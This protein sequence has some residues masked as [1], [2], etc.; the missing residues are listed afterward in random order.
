[1]VYAS[2]FPQRFL[3]LQAMFVLGFPSTTPSTAPVTSPSASSTTAGVTIPPWQNDEGA[4]TQY[5][6]T[7]QNDPQKPYTT[8]PSSN[9]TTTLS[10][11]SD[12][13]T[14]EAS[15]NV[16][17]ASSTTH[18]VTSVSVPSDKETTTTT[19]EGTTTTPKENFTTATSVSVTKTTST[20][21]TKSTVLSS[22]QSTTE[23]IVSS[24]APPENSEN[25]NGK[26]ICIGAG[27]FP[28]VKQC[29]LFHVCINAFIQYID[30]PIYCPGRSLY[31]S[32]MKKCTNNPVQ[33]PGERDLVCLTPG[34]FPH[35]DDCSKYYKCKFRSIHRDFDL[36]LFNCPIGYAYS[37]SRKRC[38]K[39]DTCNGSLDLEAFAC[40]EAGR[41]PVEGSC[42]D[43]YECRSKG[44]ELY[45]NMKTCP[46]MKLFDRQSGR[47]RDYFLV[48]CPFD[49]DDVESDYIY[50][51]SIY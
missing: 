18:S 29:N 39:S 6:S 11:T 44:D 36:I 15:S 38:V 3:I 41:F 51:D 32:Y 23:V 10:P 46:L 19:K 9:S 47:C 25:S 5:S 8:V 20:Q 37:S 2:S 7:A 13:A 16:T 42:T 27:K 31:D 28:D 14:S 45:L 21:A 17:T 35:P 49:D 4:E 48:D 40:I 34:I 22:S 26:F 30:V 33:C 1:M 50:Q 12:G 43:Y 24:L